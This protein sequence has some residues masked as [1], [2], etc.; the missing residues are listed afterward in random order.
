M[1]VRGISNYGES[2]VS[3]VAVCLLLLALGAGCATAAF[4]EVTLLDGDGKSFKKKL[5]DI[6]YNKKRSG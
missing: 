3:R 1:R 5:Q 6:T 2:L 4:Q